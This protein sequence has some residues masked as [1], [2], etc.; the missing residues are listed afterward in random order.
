M[1]SIVPMHTRAPKKY[2]LYTDGSA[3]NNTPD[4]ANATEFFFIGGW[5]ACVVDPYDNLITEGFGSH[6]NSTSSRME[7]TAAVKGLEWIVADCPPESIPQVHVV[8]DSIYV[9]KGASVYRKTWIA[10]DWISSTGR[11]IKNRDLWESLYILID[12]CHEVSWEH[13]RGHQ[14][15]DKWNERADNLARTASMQCKRS[16]GL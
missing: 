2:K 12:Q 11:A 1:V 13:I 8:T 5:A 16:K 3:L 7:L 9:V 10:N 4:K 14:G 6:D 15:I